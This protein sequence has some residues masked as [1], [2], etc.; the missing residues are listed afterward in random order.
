MRTEGKLSSFHLVLTK[1]KVRNFLEVQGLRFQSS[2]V[3]STG[4]IPGQGTKIPHAARP[5]KKKK[6]LYA[7]RDGR[8]FCKY[9][10][11]HWIVQVKA[12]ELCVSYNNKNFKNQIKWRLTCH[13]SGSLTKNKITDWRTKV[14]TR[15]M[16][17][18]PSEGCKDR[19]I[20][21]Q[22]WFLHG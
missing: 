10:K 4:S 9:I 7:C 6:T 17:W 3:G 15:R 11:N 5:K 8:Q 21:C 2:N 13:I 14:V 20:W 1:M 12:S 22:S 16:W 18:N 19:R